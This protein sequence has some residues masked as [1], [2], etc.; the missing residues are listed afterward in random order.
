MASAAFRHVTLLYARHDQGWC[1]YLL[2]NFRLDEIDLRLVPL[3]VDDTDYENPPGTLFK[4]MPWDILVVVVVVVV[5]V[6]DVVV[7]LVAFL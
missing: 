1:D 2:K 4:L 3:A 6:E 5:V 7:V